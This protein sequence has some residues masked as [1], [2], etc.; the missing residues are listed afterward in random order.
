M[1]YLA[2][3]H[4]RH[5]GKVLGNGHCVALVR[6]CAGLPPT[7]AWRRGVP[8]RGSDCAP[9]TVIATFDPDGRYGDHTDG[10]SHAAILISE[11]SDGLLVTDQWLG[12][13]V[14]QRVI[15]YRDGNGDAANDGDRY[16]VI[17]IA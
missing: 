12:Q 16:R 9:G 13:P 17:E 11:N 6:E 14:H 1:P 2:H 10:R 15:R 4:Q 5:M 3:D 7:A 8:V